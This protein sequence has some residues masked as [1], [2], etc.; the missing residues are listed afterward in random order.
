MLISFNIAQGNKNCILGWMK[1]SGEFSN[2]KWE[3]LRQIEKF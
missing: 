1:A 3:D 2:L